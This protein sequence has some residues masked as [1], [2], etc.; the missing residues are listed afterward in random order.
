MGWNLMRKSFSMVL[1]HVETRSPHSIGFL[2]LVD[3]PLNDDRIDRIRHRLYEIEWE[4]GEVISSVVEI[5]S[6]GIA[7]SIGLC[8]F[9]KGLQRK[10]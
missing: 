7:T 8:P 5:A 10:G 4:S 9:I 6:N 3:G 1:G 2:V